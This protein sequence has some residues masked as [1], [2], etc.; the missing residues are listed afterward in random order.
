PPALDATHEPD[1]TALSFSHTEFALTAEVPSAKLKDHDM[2]PGVRRISAAPRDQGIGGRSRPR[3]R[4]SD[5]PLLD[6]G[7]GAT[8]REGTCDEAPHRGV[9]SGRGEG[10]SVDGARVRRGRDG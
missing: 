1:A 8:R 9:D 3:G 10:C 6:P 2:E 4:A 7:I 5:G